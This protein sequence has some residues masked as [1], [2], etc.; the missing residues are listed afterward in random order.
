[1]AGT[2]FDMDLTK[3]IV[4]KMRMKAGVRISPELMHSLSVERFT[5]HVADELIYQLEILLAGKKETLIKEE[6][7]EIGAI[8]VP[9]SWWQHFKHDCF[10]SW[11]LKHFPPKYERKTI[12]INEKKYYETTNI[13]PHVDTSDARPHIEFMMMNIPA[14]KGKE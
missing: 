1:M 12:Y 6:K 10:P 4:N 14:K 11:L 13:C 8:S 5:N 9:T 7:R 3:V 2:T